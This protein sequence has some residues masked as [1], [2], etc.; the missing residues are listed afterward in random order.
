MYMNVLFNQLDK[1]SVCYYRKGH[2]HK[3][4]LKTKNKLFDTSCV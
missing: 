2:Q 3:Q 1:K 4:F